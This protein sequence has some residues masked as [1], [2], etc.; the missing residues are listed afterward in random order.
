MILNFLAVYLNPD[1]LTGLGIL[2]TETDHQ[3][4]RDGLLQQLN[5]KRLFR[6]ALV[7]IRGDQQNTQQALPEPP[8]PEPDG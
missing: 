6:E 4:I 8:Q 7:R 2:P 5:E 1:Q 3:K